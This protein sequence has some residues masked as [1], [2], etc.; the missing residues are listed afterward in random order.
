MGV[1][2]LS[3]PEG[4]ATTGSEAGSLADGSVAFRCPLEN[5]EESPVSAMWVV[6]G[7]GHARR[8]SSIPSQLGQSLPVALALSRTDLFRIGHCDVLG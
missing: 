1:D 4:A 2:Q 3:A 7:I 6:G 5:P 8:K